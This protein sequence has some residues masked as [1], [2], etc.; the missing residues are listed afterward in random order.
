MPEP[1]EVTEP[2]PPVE[3]GREDGPPEPAEPGGEEPLAV[4]AIETGTGEGAG[5]EGMEEA[6]GLEPPPFR[7]PSTTRKILDLLKRA[8]GIPG[9]DSSDEEVESAPEPEMEEIRRVLDDDPEPPGADPGAEGAGDSPGNPPPTPAER[10]DGGG[11]SPEDRLNEA[12]RRSQ[13]ADQMN[14]EQAAGHLKAAEKHLQERSFGKAR[15]EALRAA[16]LDPELRDEAEK[17]LLRINREE[18]KRPDSP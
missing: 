2:P 1:V 6:S 13:A 17:I 15:E 3:V 9:S 5:G 12:L 11:A 8:V 7:Q 10:P 18:N 4:P 14:R 16:R